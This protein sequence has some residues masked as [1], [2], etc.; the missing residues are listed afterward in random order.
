MAS[1]TIK[2]QGHQCER[3][4]HQWVPRNAEGPK[5]RVCPKCESPYWDQPRAEA[6]NRAGVQP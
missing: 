3:C 4:G 1:I 2:I 6:N 5:A